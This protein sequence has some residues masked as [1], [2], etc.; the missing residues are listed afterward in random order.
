M[1]LSELQHQLIKRL[2][3]GLPIGK[4]PYANIAN[5][6]GTTEKTVIETLEQLIAH[7]VINRFGMIIRHRAL[8]YQ[9]N[10]MCVFDIGD[11]TASDIG[12]AMATLPYVTLC[13]RRERV[14]GVWP[15]NLYCMIH[16]RDRLT[17]RAQIRH[18]MARLELYDTPHKVLFSKQCFTQRAGKYGAPTAS[19]SLSASRP[20]STQT[21][22]FP[23]KSGKYHEQA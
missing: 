2:R 23:I 22:P 7:K 19:A 9:A 5:D 1:E 14:A 15:Y 8:G 11:D 21:I 6:L 3:D 20:A 4:R 13:Y 12:K 16:G 18:L 17:V 10:A